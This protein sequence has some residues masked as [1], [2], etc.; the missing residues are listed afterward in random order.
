[1]CAFSHRQDQGRKCGQMWVRAK[2]LVIWKNDAGMGTRV[3]GG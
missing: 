1:M 3:Y 2:S